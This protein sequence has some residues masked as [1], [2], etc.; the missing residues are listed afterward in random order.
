MKD[1]SAAVAW[2]S[3]VF[4]FFHFLRFLKRYIAGASSFS[5]FRM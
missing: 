2:A 4:A 3:A 5:A 1:D